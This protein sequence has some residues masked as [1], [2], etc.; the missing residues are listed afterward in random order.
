MQILFKDAS[1]SSVPVSQS[2]F[3]NLISPSSNYVN[4]LKGPSPQ[5]NNRDGSRDFSNDNPMS[6]TQNDSILKNEQNENGQ[7]TIERQF[8]N[9]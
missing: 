1:K 7:N 5:V 2:F 4:N 3:D 6:I 9:T 8:I